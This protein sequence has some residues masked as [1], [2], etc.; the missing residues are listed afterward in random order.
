MNY[1]SLLWLGVCLA[2]MTG[3]CQEQSERIVEKIVEKSTLQ[4]IVD[5]A[6]DGDTI[7]LSQYSD[8]GSYSAAGIKS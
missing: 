3:C 8:L 2:I 1:K 7:D 5:S 4:D 6:N